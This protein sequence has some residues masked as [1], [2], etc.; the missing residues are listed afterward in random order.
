MMTDGMPHYAEDGQILIQRALISVSDRTGLIDLVE[1]LVSIGISLTA[2]GGTGDYLRQRGFPVRELSSISNFR[3]LLGGRVKSLHPAVH[4]AILADRKDQNHLQ[5]LAILDV[6]PFDL[7]VG[8]LYPFESVAKENWTPAAKEAVDIGGPAMI[9]AAA[10]NHDWVT[11]VTEPE[12]YAAL[13]DNLISG[14]GTVSYLFRRQMAVSVFEK[15]AAYDSMIAKSLSFEGFKEH[16]TLKLQQVKRLR[17]GE[18]PNQSAVFYGELPLTGIAAADQLV[19]PELG[20]NNIADADAA[21]SL[22]TEFAPEQHSFCTIVKH[23]SPC[24][25][26][27]SFTL[28]KAF[29]HAKDTDSLSA[30]G[31]VIGLNQT[32][33]IETAK[34][35]CMHFFELVIAPGIDQEALQQFKVKN[36]IRLL[37]MPDQDDLQNNRIEMRS[38]RGGFLAQNC[39]GTVNPKQDWVVKSKIKP[40]ERQWSD[41]EFAWKVAKFAKSNAVVTAFNGAAFGIGAGRTSRVD[42]AVSAAKPL[43]QLPKGEPIVAASDGFFPFPDGVEVLAKAGVQAIIQPGG[44]KQ[45]TDIIAVADRFGLAMVFTGMRQFRH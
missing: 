16:K 9:R 4:A 1:F 30:F 26:A 41:L 22:V 25:A 45:D 12:D 37:I 7:V 15:T 3:E 21:W 24:G 36:R 8:G 14:D 39:C 33:D 6:E 5:D 42:A 31:G 23:G 11:V 44:S 13:I 38:V 29:L 34:Q 27:Q 28:S 18:N 2:T 43:T 19:G 40:V 10:K 17:Y 20:Y 32:I 35:I